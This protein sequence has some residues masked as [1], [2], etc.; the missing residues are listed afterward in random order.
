MTGWEEK[1]PAQ[2]DKQDR[3]Q[4]TQRGCAVSVLGDFQDLTG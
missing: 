2:E 1:L 3:E 4:V